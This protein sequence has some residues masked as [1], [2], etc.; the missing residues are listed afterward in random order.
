MAQFGKFDDES[1]QQFIADFDSKVNGQEMA[2]LMEG[3]GKDL[4]ILLINTVKKKTPPGPSKQLK[5]NWFPGDLKYTGN[6]LT[7][8]VHNNLEYAPHVEYGHRQTPGRYVPA[9]GKR[10][11]RDYVPGKH[12]L[13]NSMNELDSKLDQILGAKVDKFLHDFFWG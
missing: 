7:V 4:Q 3:I 10:L 12:M 9:I 2:N 11:K 8:E 1:L 13:E 6:T 5:R